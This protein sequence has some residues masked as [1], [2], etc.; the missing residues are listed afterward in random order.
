MRGGIFGSLFDLN[1]DGEL[2]AFEQGME[3]MALQH[4]MDAESEKD[5]DIGQAD[6]LEAVGLSYT[7]L[8]LMDEDERRE[9]LEDAGLSPDDFD[10]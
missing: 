8:L 3:F 1:G 6:E 4:M 10:F 2:D 9:V 5:L 7:N